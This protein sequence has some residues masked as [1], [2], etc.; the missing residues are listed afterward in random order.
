MPA[1]KGKGTKR[2]P[3]P[4]RPTKTKLK[5]PPK[6]IFADPTSTSVIHGKKVSVG[7]GVGEQ[8]AKKAKAAAKTRAQRI[9]EE[10]EGVFNN[11]S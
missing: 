4:P 11:G 3:M 8:V 10:L 9:R 6:P 2:M 5:V 7:T 1:K